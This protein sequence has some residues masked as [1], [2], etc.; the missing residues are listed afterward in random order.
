MTKNLFHIPFE[1]VCTNQED[2]ITFKNNLLDKICNIL[3]SRNSH[4]DRIAAL[5]NNNIY[6]ENL[7]M[8]N[9][10]PYELYL[11]VNITKSNIFIP[12]NKNMLMLFKIDGMCEDDGTIATYES[13]LSTYIAPIQNK[14]E[15]CKLAHMS[16]HRDDNKFYISDQLIDCV[17][18]YFNTDKSVLISACE[19]FDIDVITSDNVHDNETKSYTSVRNYLSVIDG[20][21]IREA[22]N[23]INN[24]NNDV[25]SK[26]HIYL[27]DERSGVS[28][29]KR[30]STLM[31]INV[32]TS[33]AVM[34]ALKEFYDKIDTISLDHDLGNDN[35]I[36]TGYDVLLWLEKYIFNNEEIRTVPTLLV[37]SVNSSARIKME[38]AISAI[39]NKIASRNTQHK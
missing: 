2:N 25:V 20:I 34:Y 32:K 11:L 15:L 29:D 19:S 7:M 13:A 30:L 5:I 24:Q 17:Y 6:V 37:H 18:N 8:I 21:I 4:S 23:K 12:A 14:E 28:E 1:L 33:W 22:I 39:N 26:L 36:G 16:K 9:D 35:K 27:D 10:N 38:L 3:N 31:Y